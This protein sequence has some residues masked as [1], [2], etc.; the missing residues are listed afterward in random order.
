[1]LAHKS[2]VWWKKPSENW[3]N[4]SSD[5]R[6]LHF[7]EPLNTSPLTP[8]CVVNERSVCRNKNN[9]KDLKLTIWYSSST[10]SGDE[11]KLAKMQRQFLAV[12]WDVLLLRTYSEGTCFTIITYYK[13]VMCLPIMADASGKPVKWQLCLSAF[14]FDIVA[15]AYLR[16]QV[17]DALSSRNT[18]RNDITL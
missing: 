13:T 7:S 16:N 14:D 6:S 1:M 9:A 8:M 15:R 18:G 10:L 2:N 3:S 12:V 11:R 5:L 17:E 4:Y